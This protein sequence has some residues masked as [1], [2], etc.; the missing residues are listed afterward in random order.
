MN[1]NESDPLIL[2]QQ[3]D[4]TRQGEELANVVILA[5]P[6]SLIDDGIPVEV[7]TQIKALILKATQQA[8]NLQAGRAFAPKYI[9]AFETAFKDAVTS[10]LIKHGTAR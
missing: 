1:T 5:F 2:G 4:G 6:R 9:E 7:A 10:T 8:V 3:F